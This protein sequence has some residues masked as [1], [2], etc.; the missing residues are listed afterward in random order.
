MFETLKRLYDEGRLPTEW[1]SNAVAKEW[2]T[3]EQYQTI[4]NSYNQ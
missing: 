4:T 2:I 3:A 1:L